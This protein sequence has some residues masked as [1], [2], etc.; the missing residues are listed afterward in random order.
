MV[1]WLRELWVRFYV[2]ARLDALT[3]RDLQASWLTVW[4]KMRSGRARM[5]WFDM[6]QFRFL[7][8]PRKGFW[9]VVGLMVVD[10]VVAYHLRWLP[11]VGLWLCWRLGVFALVLHLLFYRWEFFFGRRL[12]MN[13]HGRCFLAVWVGVYLVR[14]ILYP[15]VLVFHGAEPYFLR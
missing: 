2:F 4:V 6:G 13:A 3:W 1:A 5:W 9:L 15:A 7:W 14:F 12:V 10:N 8:K 11:G